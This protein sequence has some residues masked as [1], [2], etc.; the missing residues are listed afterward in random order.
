MED[1][2]TPQGTQ[3]R[4]DYDETVFPNFNW[5]GYANYSD[6]QKELYI[7]TQIDQPSIYRPVINYVNL[8]NESINGQLILSPLN[9]VNNQELPQTIQLQL[10]PTNGQAKKH[11]PP[12]KVGIQSVIPLR[13]GK[14]RMQ[15][16]L[17][18]PAL[19]DYLVLLPEEY[20]NA[21]SLIDYFE[22][23]CTLTQQ[24][25]PNRLCKLYG[26][27]DY[28]RNS[29]ILTVSQLASSPNFY[30][31][32]QLIEKLTKNS[33]L[34]ATL[35]TEVG[36]EYKFTPKSNGKHM[37]IVNYHHFDL[38]ENQSL[39]GKH[40]LNKL[41]LKLKKLTNNAPEPVSEERSLEENKDS[42]KVDPIKNRTLYEKFLRNFIDYKISNEE[43]VTVDITKCIY[44]FTCRQVIKTLEDDIAIFE[45]SKQEDYQLS[46][47]PS[48][49]ST[50]KIGKLPALIDLTLIPI[51]DWSLDYVRG[52]VI[53]SRNASGFCVANEFLDHENENNRMRFV[54]R[55]E[56][57]QTE[58]EKDSI[59]KIDENNAIDLSQS[60]YLNS[61]QLTVIA[62][63]SVPEPKLY[64]FVV[65]Y[66]QPNHA[67]FDMQSNIIL[68]SGTKKE[69]YIP[70][71]IPI[72]YCPNV[73][74]CKT[75]IVTTTNGTLFELN[76]AFDLAVV[77]PSEK[78]VYIK[79]INVLPNESFSPTILSAQPTHLPQVEFYK[80]CAQDAFFINATLY[81]AYWNQ[82]TNSL[83]LPEQNEERNAEES[84]KVSKF[85]RDT[86]YGLAIR[87]NK[88][89]I[90]CNCDS[91][92]SLSTYDCAHLGGQCQCRRK[93]TIII[94]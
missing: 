25:E 61:N 37:L 23:P 27:P 48:E 12:I 73:S 80:E 49:N 57:T 14:W 28:T 89:A 52:D 64:T 9:Q 7:D 79:K 66:Y 63:G 77:F 26:Y 10:E 36:Q 50:Q 1:A 85:C 8:G 5:K 91:R 86:I 3:A 44:A 93:C 29:T 18:K 16:K 83:M 31:K 4:Y 56:E 70:S 43:P 60:N 40:Q 19:V 34:K 58:T 90:P 78:S 67:T 87:F 15:L 32:Q 30:D 24:Q 82:T 35:I 76:D 71:K 11:L 72:K 51:D 92:G 55:S 38:D 54:D 47:K 74:G 20:W 42:I 81:N 53:C 46:V 68:N 65:E 62:S 59:Y 6:I 45:L 21:H 22:L 75:Q 84:K 88:G 39:Q 41:D 13:Q 33:D 17:D 94:L 2:I 69:T